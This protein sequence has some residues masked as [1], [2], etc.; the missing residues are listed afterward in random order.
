MRMAG[1]IFAPGGG[2]TGV[3]RSG[4]ARRWNVATF[5]CCHLPCLRR[6]RCITR[7]R[8]RPRIL[9]SITR[10]GNGRN[11]IVTPFSPSNSYP[12]LLVR[13]SRDGLLSVSSTG[14]VSA[15]SSART[16]GTSSHSTCTR[17]FRYFRRRLRGNAFEGVILTEGTAIQATSGSFRDLFVGTYQVCPHLFI[18]LI[19]APRSKV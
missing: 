15:S 1:C 10:L 4:G 2:S 14:I 12:I 7:Q 18:S 5:T 6:T 9:S 8:N 3:R 17:S 19:C 11:F 16:R 13:P